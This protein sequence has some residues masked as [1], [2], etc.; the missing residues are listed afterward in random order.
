MSC[1]S[2]ITFIVDVNTELSDDTTD[3][4]TCTDVCVQLDDWR[5]NVDF[6]Y[7]ILESLMNETWFKELQD[8]VYYIYVRGTIE[9]DI[10]Q[11]WETGIWECDG[12]YLN[13]DY[14]KAEKF[15]PLKEV[16]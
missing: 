2:C 3:R 16:I 11:D 6:Q 5:A 14:H 8:G 4:Y 13:P 15:D 12:I 7:D 1:E 10:S 9:W